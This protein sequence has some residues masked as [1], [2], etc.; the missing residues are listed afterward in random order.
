MVPVRISVNIVL[1]LPRTTVGAFG[2]S[3]NIGVFFFFSSFL[4]EERLSH[5]IDCAFFLNN[6]YLK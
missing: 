6:T 1:E 4:S 3:S 2:A 5:G